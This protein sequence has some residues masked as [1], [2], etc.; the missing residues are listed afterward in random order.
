[1]AYKVFDDIKSDYKTS[2]DTSDNIQKISLNNTDTQRVELPD[3]SFV[4]DADITRDGVDLVLETDTGTV[5]IEGYFTAEPAPNLYAPDGTALTPNL[6]NAFTHGGDQYADSGMMA[7][8]LSPV[9]AVQEITGNATVTRVNGAVETIGIGTPIYAGDVVETDD[10]GAVNITFIDETSFAVSEDARLSIDEYVFD[11]ATQSGTTNFSVLKG[12]FVFTSGLIGRDDPDDVKIETPSG[13][14]GIRGTIIAG[15]VDAGEIT[16]IEGAIVLQDLAGNSV[17]L[18]DQ[19]ATA[20][21]DPAGGTIEQ[22]GNLGAAD[23]AS[24]FMSIS[25]VA[26]DLFSSIQD[27]AT[28]TGQDNNAESGEE[29]K[30]AAQD[31]QETSEDQVEEAVQDTEAVEAAEEAPAE[32]EK[33][34]SEDTEASDDTEAQQA[35]EEAGDDKDASLETEATE[36]VTETEAVDVVLSED[37]AA[38]A[39]TN[40]AQTVQPAGAS[41]AQAKPAT[42]PPTAS[43]NQQ[44]AADVAETQQPPPQTQQQGNQFDV[45]VTRLAVNENDNAAPQ[46]LRIQGQF[47]DLTNVQL[48]GTSGNYYD[49]ISEDAN[50]YV[51]QLKTGVSLDAENLYPLNFR[52]TNSDGTSEIIRNVDLNVID[53]NEL[54]DVD[55]NGADNVTN[56]SFFKAS[57]NSMFEYDFSQEFSDPEGDA[58]TYTI[59]GIDGTNAD[60]STFN[61]DASTGALSF[62]MENTISVA[63]NGGIAFTVTAT[64][65]VNTESVNYTF[66]GV[67]GPSSPSAGSIFGGGQYATTDDVI[68]VSGASVTLFT[69]LDNENDTITLQNAADNAYVKTGG[70]DDNVIIDNGALNYK[71]FGGKGSDSYDINETQ[72]DI[73]AGDGSDNFHIHNDVAGLAGS[74]LDGGQGFDV[75]HVSTTDS[76][77]FTAITSGQITNVE[78]L[79]FINGNANTITLNYDNVIDM[80]DAD[81]R[82]FIDLDA[83]DTL[84]FNNTSGNDFVKVEDVSTQHGEYD[85]YTDGTITVLVNSDEFVSAG[86]F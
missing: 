82:L 42:P 7:S 30:D 80:T 43:E 39:N 23:V 5:V 6:V 18:A 71:I 24:K 73:H 56:T 75:F 67:N 81:N 1:M 76:V 10:N 53:Q 62:T 48:A 47:T 11:P 25:T 77:D 12:V 21:F 8:D 26:G 4:K 59:S 86:S 32:A 69:D 61:F 14:I 38:T 46:V 2:D 60:I 44:Q 84:N 34:A 79:G 31:T 52:A 72:G 55:V 27:A 37:V 41:Q 9:G 35:D 78:R 19:F 29:A 66:Y 51:V 20:K 68:N 13:S 58:L 16:V 83:G 40:T 36:E 70:G 57:N 74:R 54:I 64:D 63:S 65:G 3:S 15:D 17:T 33:A 22:M 50:T 45:V 28:E 49:L 85:S